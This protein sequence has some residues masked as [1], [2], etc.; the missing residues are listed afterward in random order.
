MPTLAQG[1]GVALAAASAW[2]LTMLGRARARKRD[3][4]VLMIETFVSPGHRVRP[5]LPSVL[6]WGTAA[7]FLAGALRAVDPRVLV[8]LGLLVGVA[9][10][11]HVALGA[12]VCFSFVRPDIGLLLTWAA[13]VAAG[14]LVRVV[15]LRTVMWRPPM[16]WARR[17]QRWGT[18][19]SPP[20][21]VDRFWQAAAA[22]AAAAP[23]VALAVTWNHPDLPLRAACAVLVAIQLAATDRAWRGR[24]RWL[25]RMGRGVVALSVAA[26]AL[27][28][29]T[30][31]GGWLAG[32]W[33]SE[34]HAV[35]VSGGITLS[36]I[37]FLA[38]LGLRWPAAIWRLLTR[39]VRLFSSRGLVPFW[40]VVVFHDT[41]GPLVAATVLIAAEALLTLS[42]R[43]LGRYDV[44][45]EGEA[46]IYAQTVHWK[47]ATRL[48][49]FGPWLYDGIVHRRK[50]FDYG[51]VRVYLGMAVLGARG[52]AAPGQGGAALGSDAWRP[53]TGLDAL[54]WTG[55]AAQALDLIDG[56]ALP[57][58]AEDGPPGG[59]SRDRA[60]EL[61]L[62]Q[63]A[64]RA[65]L[66]LAR[67]V[68]LAHAEQWHEALNEWR[69]ATQQ[70]RA[71]GESAAERSARTATAW[72][73][74]CRLDQPS[75]AR[76]ELARVTPAAGPPPGAPDRWHPELAEGVAALVTA[77]ETELAGLHASAP[78]S[79]SSTTSSDTGR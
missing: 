14:A 42:G 76:R 46:R 29:S 72:L 20:M 16:S 32:Q 68:V 35:G 37:A 9:G 10:L 71:L 31:L 27:L 74:A 4:R 11:P 38:W 13:P 54:R 26:T 41:H 39:L 23:V 5:L 70:Y 51:P 2:A 3:P 57:R 52:R 61:D 8:L 62:R 60:G 79:E 67:A 22:G 28:A 50:G 44:I 53:L 56:E 17:F 1:L 40:T 49:L 55:A 18:V 73:L 12:A 63:R 30:P 75:A 36:A 21:P 77:A 19:L 24:H 59:G 47:P 78:A 15:H 58:L 65:D 66:A 69:D 43:L 7:F 45:D 48:S 34:R 64:A 33:A 25:R 6:V